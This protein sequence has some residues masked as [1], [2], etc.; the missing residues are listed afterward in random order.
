MYFDELYLIDKKKKKRV[1]SHG[2]IYIYVHEG[3]RG[4]IR[5][6]KFLDALVH[7]ANREY[8]AFTFHVDENSVVER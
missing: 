7:H 2:F 1:N 3:L 5:Q 8:S 6:G 4:L